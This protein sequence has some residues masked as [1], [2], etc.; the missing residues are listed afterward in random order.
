MLSVHLA[1]T[2]QHDP[3]TPVTDL[4]VTFLTGTCFSINIHTLSSSTNHW[5]VDSGA[6][7]NICPITS[8]F[9]FLK[10]ISRASV[11]L[12]NHT[13]IVV[14]LAGDV[15]LS[16]TLVLKDVLFI[17][18]FRFNLL[19]V[20]AL[21]TGRDLTITFQPDR[22]EIQDPMSR[23][24]IGKGDKATRLYLLD[25]T[26]LC[27]PYATALD[28]VSTASINTVSTSTWHNRLGHPSLKVLG[29]LKSQLLCDMSYVNKFPPFYVCPLV[30][31]RRLSFD[32]QNNM[33]IALFEKVHCDIWGPYHFHPTM[34]F[35][36]ILHW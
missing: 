24:T 18:D 4:A 2:P 29:T 7:R 8:L 13:S 30:K 34:V 21:L 9:S 27:S 26:A 17:P 16:S 3:G 22:F 23:K 25:A 15:R 31:H 12:P 36:T 32:P 28:L 33:A 5:I 1:G 14:T 11:T 10:P 20:S 35:V 19:S 6:T